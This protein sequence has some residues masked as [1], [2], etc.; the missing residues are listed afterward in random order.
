[1][2]KKD[3][4][5]LVGNYRKAIVLGIGKNE[6]TTKIQYLD[7]M[8]KIKNVWNSQIHGDKSYKK[9]NGKIRNVSM[10]Y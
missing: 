2:H 9:F 4:I 8:K 3:D 6:N 5:I 10:Q 7:G 1:M